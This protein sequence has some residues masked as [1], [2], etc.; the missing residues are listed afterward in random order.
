M[1]LIHHTRSRSEWRVRFERRLINLTN[2][3]LHAV[4]YFLLSAEVYETRFGDVPE[5]AARDMLQPPGDGVHD[6]GIA[7]CTAILFLRRFRLPREE[8]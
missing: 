6:D 3:E 8:A 2:G 7:A 4:H 1:T 5:D